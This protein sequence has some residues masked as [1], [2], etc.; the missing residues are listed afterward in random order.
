MAAAVLE[1]A[2]GEPGQ[3]LIDSERQRDLLQRALAA[4]ARFRR[5]RAAGTSADLL[6]ADLTDALDA[7]GEITGAVSSAEILERMFAGFCVGK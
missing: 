3:P 4:V 2:S 1:G 5:A 6:A 7:L